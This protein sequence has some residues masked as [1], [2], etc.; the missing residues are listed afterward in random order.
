MRKSRAW[1]LKIF[2][3]RRIDT[4]SKRNLSDMKDFT[5]PW[6]GVHIPENIKF[7]SAGVSS[8]SFKREAKTFSL[9]CSFLEVFLVTLKEWGQNHGR[10][11]NFQHNT[12]KYPFWLKSIVYWPCS[13]VLIIKSGNPRIFSLSSESPYYFSIVPC[14]KRNTQRT[15]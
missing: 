5:S 13:D 8:Y 2:D 15:L 12:I 6:E 7:F 10:P 3:F 11:D 14:L 4:L 9:E 1:N